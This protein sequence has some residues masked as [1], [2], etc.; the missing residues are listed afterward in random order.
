MTRTRRSE[1]ASAGEAKSRRAKLEE[2]A[3][4]AAMDTGRR[5]RETLETSPGM[6]ETTRR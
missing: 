5:I 6:R 4:R 1:D 2:A 3:R